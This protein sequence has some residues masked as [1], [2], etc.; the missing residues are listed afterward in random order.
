MTRLARLWR[1]ELPL[2]E[3]FWTWAVF[4]GLCVNITTSLSFLTLIMWDQPWLALLAGYGFSLP[5]NL[6]VLVGVW[7]SAGSYD[8]PQLHA[9][10]AR[11]ASLILLGILSVT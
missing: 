11:G 7:R 10:L 8:G 2:S 9:D 3:A 4:W 5:Y 6:L 1:G